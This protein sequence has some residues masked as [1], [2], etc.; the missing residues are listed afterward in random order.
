MHTLLLFF[1]LDELG[2]VRSREGVT[3]P[4]RR[5]GIKMKIIVGEKKE[6]WVKKAKEIESRRKDR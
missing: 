6:E 4:C 2:K 1:G 3:A 5:G